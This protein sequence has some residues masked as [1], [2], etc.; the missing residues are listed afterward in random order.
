MNDI[1]GKI[2]DGLN[3]FGV[4]FG[5]FVVVPTWFEPL[6]EY[7]DLAISFMLVIMCAQVLAL[8]IRFRN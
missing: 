5:I 8:R 2:A 4:A 1:S 6:Q 7:N 3:F